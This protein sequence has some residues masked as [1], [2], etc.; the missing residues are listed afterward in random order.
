[1]VKNVTFISNG[2]CKNINKFENWQYLLYK[3]TLE[4]GIL[5]YEVRKIEAWYVQKIKVYSVEM[6]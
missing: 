2:L 5:K 1:M 6:I 3:I 4:S